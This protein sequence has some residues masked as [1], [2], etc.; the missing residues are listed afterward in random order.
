MMEARFGDAAAEP[1]S[2]DVRCPIECDGQIEGPSRHEATTLGDDLCSESRDPRAIFRGET[3]SRI[4]GKEPE[5]I[6]PRFVESESTGSEAPLEISRFLPVTSKLVP[7]SSRRVKC[8]RRSTKL[9]IDQFSG[10]AGI[11]G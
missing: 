7:I 3:I 11:V 4:Q 8:S 9:S 2:V 5:L 10:M 6:E 1:V